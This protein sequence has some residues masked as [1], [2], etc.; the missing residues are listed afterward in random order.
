ME[1][2]SPQAYSELLARIT[3]LESLLKANNIPFDKYNPV[4]NV[5]AN[6]A[7]L[8]SP[9]KTS[10]EI[11]QKN[12]E[13]PLTANLIERYSRQMFLSE[14]SYQGQKKIVNSRVLVVGAG[15]I[16]APALYYLAGM[17]IGT[18]GI[19]DGDKVEESN[20]HRQI[21]HK[22][23]RIGMNKALSALKTLSKYNPNPKY[24]VYP[25]NLTIKNANEIIKKYD[26][27][28]DA[29]DNAL[30]RYL[31][32]DAVH[33]NKKILISGSALGWEGQLTVFGFETD[34]PCYRCLFPICPKN[35][36][37]CGE[38]GV[39][40]MVPGIIGLLQAIETMKIIVGVPGILSKEMLVY[41]SIRSVFKKAKLRG[42]QK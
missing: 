18:I 21:L 5:K 8:S 42:K 28:L 40:G 35:M 27:V 9:L 33:L 29:S 30:T 38:A 22:N 36:M 15:G 32:N 37:T 26:I 34:A 41:D 19:I 20:L 2:N 25:E 24:E 23:K 7:L 39:V 14:I 1:G 13:I 6:L 4:Q 17:G 10:L 16:G 31:L 11:D 3:Y 12:N